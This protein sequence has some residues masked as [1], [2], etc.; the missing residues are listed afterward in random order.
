MPNAM[1]KQ[2]SKERGCAGKTNMGSNYKSYADKLAVKHGKRYG[3]YRCSHCGGT[4]ATTKIENEHLYYNKLLY[5]TAW[6]ENKNNA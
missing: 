5:V 6:R 2:C 3:V 1:I 4:H